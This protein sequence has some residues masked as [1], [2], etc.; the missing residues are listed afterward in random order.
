M[1]CVNK[2][3]IATTFRLK[4][5]K[6]VDILFAHNITLRFT[7]LRKNACLLIC[8]AEV[9]DFEFWYH[10]SLMWENLY[11][12][13]TVSYINVHSDNYDPRNIFDSLSIFWIY[14]DCE[15]AS[16]INFQL[17]FKGQMITWW[18]PQSWRAVNLVIQIFIQ[19]SFTFTC[20]Q[21]TIL[22]NNGSKLKI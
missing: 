14:L 3:H 21:I 22:I 16:S 20:I 7:I 19:N 13:N 18:R 5:F 1:V 2:I 10:P 11:I 12:R 17:Q 4:R 8:K 9:E 15:D 6:H